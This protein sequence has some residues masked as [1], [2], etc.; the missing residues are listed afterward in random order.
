M[1]WQTHQQTHRHRVRSAL[2][3]AACNHNYMLSHN[4]SN[5]QAKSCNTHM[6][7]RSP[8][9]KLSTVVLSHQDTSST[10]GSRLN[11]GVIH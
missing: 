4:Q 3:T 1:C 11:A 9:V 2:K 7:K 8:L 5:K 10:L 6:H